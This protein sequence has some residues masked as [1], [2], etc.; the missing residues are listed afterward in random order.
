MRDPAGALPAF[1]TFVTTQHPPLLYLKYAN[2]DAIYGGKPSET[3]ALRAMVVVCSQQAL[4]DSQAFYNRTF[5]AM[6]TARAS[7]IT[8][9][10][11]WS[12]CSC[13]G[14]SVR[15]LC[16]LEGFRFK[17]GATEYSNY[18]R[19]YGM[20]GKTSKKHAATFANSNDLRNNINGMRRLVV[21]RAESS[22]R[23]NIYQSTSSRPTWPLL[24][25]SPTPTKLK[26]QHRVVVTRNLCFSYSVDC[27]G[28]GVGMPAGHN[29]QDFNISA[30]DIRSGAWIDWI[31]VTY[32]H[33]TSGQKLVQEWGNSNGGGVPDLPKNLLTDPIVAATWGSQIRS[34]DVVVGALRGFTLLQAG[35]HVTSAGSWG[36]DTRQLTDSF[37]VWKGAV[38]LCG[39]NIH[40][41]PGNRVSGIGPHWCYNEAYTA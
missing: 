12:S 10:E 37:S 39:M 24:L 22:S 40:G 38:W 11:S 14:A 9:P 31:R 33:R 35:G 28:E 18:Q 36:D 25:A 6:L 26:L 27:G 3:A 15:S 16:C 8:Q 7:K 19:T 29:Y 30:I 20:P 5:S 34:E 21:D 32:T 4:N 13:G 17:D 1:A 23:I 41:E 2:Y